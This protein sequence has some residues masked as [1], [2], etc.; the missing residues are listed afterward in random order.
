MCL[1]ITAPSSLPLPPPVQAKIYRPVIPTFRKE[2]VASILTHVNTLP[3][4]EDWTP[5]QV[6]YLPTLPTLAHLPTYPLSLSTYLQ[7]L[8]L[9]QS[10]G[11]MDYQRP[12]AAGFMQK[13]EQACRNYLSLQHHP[14]HHRRI[15]GLPRGLIQSASPATMKNH[16]H[17]HAVTEGL[18]FTSRGKGEGGR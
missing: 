1:L 4:F 3:N 12:R 15:S 9:L 7:L 5:T 18:E 17:H 2:F 6:T 13:W 8:S 10:L 16:H 14:P 11:A